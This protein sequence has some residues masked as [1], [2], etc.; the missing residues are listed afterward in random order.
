[1]WVIP[2]KSHPNATSAHKDC[3]SYSKFFNFK[4]LNIILKKAACE[5]MGAYLVTIDSRQ[6]LQDVIDSVD[7]LK[8]WDV[9][10]GLN[11]LNEK[12]AYLWD[13]KV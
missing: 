2:K 1:M 7:K 5:Q 4:V 11:R 8:R 9:W 3:F 13:S 12:D 10:I 6:K